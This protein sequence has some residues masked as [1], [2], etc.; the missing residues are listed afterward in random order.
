MTEHNL[1]Y[2]PYASFTDAQL[3]LLKVAALWFDK[4]V[5]LDPVG[6]SWD[7]IG[8]ESQVRDAVRK[9]KSAGILEIVSPATILTKFEQ[10]IAKA[11]RSDMGDHEFLDLCDEHGRAGGKQR[12]TLSLAKVPQEIQTDQVMRHLMGDFARSVSI[13]SA[14]YLESTGRN[15]TE[16]DEYA[17]GGRSYDEYREYADDHVEYRYADFP[18][19]LGE[20]IMMNHALFAGLLHAGATPITDDPF[21]S[22]ALAHKLK[23]AASEP[24]IHRAISD[25]A[26]QRQL[27]ADVL[28]ASALM[29]T[30]IQLPILDPALPLAEVLEY[31]QT[32]AGDLQQAREK[33]VWMAR[34]IEAEPWNEDFAKE[35]EHNTIPDI[36]MELE[37]ARK[38]RDS[39]L[40][41]KRGR[42]ALK[43]AGLAAGA[44]AAA[45]AVFTAPATPVAPAAA[46]LGLVSGTAIPGAEWL[47]DWRDGKKS[48]QENGLHYLLKT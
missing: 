29:D 6:A 19:A 43:A 44:A 14:R 20:A 31:R 26:A 22:K 45:L 28:A 37:A 48:V 10:P 2:Y 4:L 38:S 36:A 32:H 23:R 13:D 47:F 3:P 41:S 11:I 18:L 1:F 33:L 8:I 7:S 30:Q 24:A 34:R 35:L 16:F 40:E 15:P 46:G 42:L 27:K 9:L 25:R 39:W 21:H 5:I 17:E 12:W